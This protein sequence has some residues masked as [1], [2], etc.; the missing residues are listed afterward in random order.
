[1]SLQNIWIIEEIAVSLILVFLF[2]VVLLFSD[3]KSTLIKQ[4]SVMLLVSN[5]SALVVYVTRLPLNK[6]EESQDQCRG[7]LL[8]TWTHS[9][10]YSL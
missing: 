6:C 7:Y 8:W 9:V 1:M 3:N 2:L 5:A 4:L 10:T